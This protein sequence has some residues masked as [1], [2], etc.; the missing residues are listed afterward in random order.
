[1]L[2]EPEDVES[3]AAGIRAVLDDQALRSRLIAA[4]HERSRSFTWNRCARETLAAL[5]RVGARQGLMP[6]PGAVPTAAEAHR[7]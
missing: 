2:V 3:I 1:V 5:E 7:P 4:G 6:S